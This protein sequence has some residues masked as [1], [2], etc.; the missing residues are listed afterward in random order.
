MII[1]ILCLL[2]IAFIIAWIGRE[3]SAIGVFTISFILA[4][5]WFWHHVTEA[6]GLSL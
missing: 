6:I 4:I 5:Y 2:L 1:I 3:K